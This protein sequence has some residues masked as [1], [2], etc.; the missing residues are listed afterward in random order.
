MTALSGPVE[1]GRK[2]G[3]V[4]CYSVAAGQ[5]IYK[6]SLVVTRLD[7]QAYN[8]RTPASGQVDVFIGVADET[9]DNTTG[10]N[11]ALTIH[12]LKKGTFQLVYPSATAALIGSL[13]YGVDTATVSSTSTNAIAIGYVTEYVD[14]NDVRVLIDRSVQ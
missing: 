11:G 14:S 9:V 5:K 12:V 8:L 7:G 3:N 1:T 2:D 6:G 4:V 13:A 10:A